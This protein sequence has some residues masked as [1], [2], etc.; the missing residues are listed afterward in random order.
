V[1]D[2]AWSLSSREKQ[3]KPTTEWSRIAG[4]NFL[5]DQALAL[6]HEKWIQLNKVP[7]ERF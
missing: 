4:E 2:E 6:G 7:Y 5:E 3:R 1:N